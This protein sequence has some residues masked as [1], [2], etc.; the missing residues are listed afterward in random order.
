MATQPLE[1]RLRISDSGELEAIH[2]PLR[3]RK[4]IARHIASLSFG[5]VTLCI[6]KGR[7][8]F[9]ERTESEAAA[10]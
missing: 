3:L 2:L 4:Q 8:R 9:I 5:R 7:I 10:S 6:E 1:K